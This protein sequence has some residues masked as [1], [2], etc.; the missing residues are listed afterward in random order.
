MTEITQRLLDGHRRPVLADPALGC[1]HDAG[2]PQQ[3]VRE[4]V[5][6]AREQH[7]EV[8]LREGQ[9]P[10]QQ[11]AEEAL[12]R[13]RTGGAA[14]LPRHPAEPHQ[15]GVQD[16]DLLERSPLENAPA[17]RHRGRAQAPPVPVG[18]GLGEKLA[19]ESM[20]IEPGIGRVGPVPIGAFIARHRATPRARGGR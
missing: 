7:R 4:Q 20:G 17:S 8:R 19:Q 5:A 1:P 13:H 6:G 15:P 12:Q 2:G 18:R 11:L 16:A 14:A 9:L 10:A 3:L